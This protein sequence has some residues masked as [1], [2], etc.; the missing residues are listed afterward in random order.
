MATTLTVKTYN[1]PNGINAC[2]VNGECQTILVLP[3]G[4]F[5]TDSWCE[6]ALLDSYPGVTLVSQTTRQ[7]PDYPPEW[8]VVND[9]VTIPHGRT[10]EYLIAPGPLG[11]GIDLL[12]CGCQGY[13]SGHLKR[14]PG[15]FVTSDRA[16]QCALFNYQVAGAGVT[17]TRDWAT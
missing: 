8:Y 15:L 6:I 7:L 3:A 16:Q 11:T 10:R 1:L 5:T 17:L 4:H 14:G 9:E 2:Y 13:G 12:Y